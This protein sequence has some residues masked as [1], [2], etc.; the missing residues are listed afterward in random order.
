MKLF[1]ALAACTIAL[2]AAGTAVA[3][4]DK[5]VSAAPAGAYKL[6]SRHASVVGRISHLG[7]SDF[8]LKFRTFDASYAFD[9]AHSQASRLD[10]TLDLASVDSGVAALDTELK[11]ERFFDTAKYPTAH[12][13]ST[14]IG[15][16]KGDHALVQGELELHGVKQPATL[17]VRYNG[18]AMQGKDQKM[19]F[20]AT[21]VV[22]R[23]AFG[24]T[25]LVGPVG[26]DV[27]LTV[28]AE[29]IKQP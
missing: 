10:I 5:D 14:S 24:V 21:L 7:L 3:A 22:K 28:E 9:P 17:D 27:H 25:A 20:S 16:V 8:T 15:A 23:S 6:D 4:P 29:F 11:G 19:G 12:F 1:P 2:L 26:D 13:V 18:S